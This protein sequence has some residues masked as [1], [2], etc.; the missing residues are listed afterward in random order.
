MCLLSEFEFGFKT[1]AKRFEGIEVVQI[2]F[3]GDHAIFFVPA[4]TDAE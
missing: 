2:E 4:F 1:L 3:H